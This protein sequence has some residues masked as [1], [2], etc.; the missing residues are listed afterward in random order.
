M[1]PEKTAP[2][3]IFS[4]F[5][6]PCGNIKGNIYATGNNRRQLPP[7]GLLNQGRTRSEK[8]GQAKL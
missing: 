3:K 5:D 7:M 4:V 1:R 6:A 8:S 2:E